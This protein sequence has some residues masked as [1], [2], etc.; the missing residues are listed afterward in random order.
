MTKTAAQKLRQKEKRKAKKQQQ[1]SGRSRSRSAASSRRSRSASSKCSVRTDSAATRKSFPSRPTRKASVR[2]A[3]VGRSLNLGLMAKRAFAQATLPYDAKMV[4]VRPHGAGC[5]LQSTAM[6]RNFAVIDIDLSG[7]LAVP[8]DAN[9]PSVHLSSSYNQLVPLWGDGRSVQVVQLHDPLIYGIYPVANPASVHSIYN[10]TNFVSEMCVDTQLHGTSG[11]SAALNCELGCWNGAIGQNLAPS[12]FLPAAGSP[13][14]K[15]GNLLPCFSRNKGG[16]S[17]LRY[18]W[19]DASPAKP[20]ALTVDLATVAPGHFAAGDAYVR[21][22][23]LNYS[24]TVDVISAPVPVT[25]PGAIGTVA[26]NIASSGCYAVIILGAMSGAA[27]AG[28]V[29]TYRPKLTLDMQTTLATNYVFN[30]NLWDTRHQVERIQVNGSAVLV[31]NTQAVMGRGNMVYAVSVGEQDAWWADFT[32]DPAKKIIATNSSSRYGGKWEEGIYGF[33]RPV[34]AFKFEEYFKV[35]PSGLSENFT[36]LLDCDGM[37]VFSIGATASADFSPRA[38]AHFC[39]V[40]EFTT[41][42]QMFVKDVSEIGQVETGELVDLLQ[43]QQPFTENPLHWSSILDA[44]R[45]GANKVLE[46]APTVARYANA[47]LSIASVLAA[48]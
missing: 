47:G 27:A 25:A 35:N 30:Q 36:D 16:V 7:V 29:M 45:S 31:Q 2:M 23:R 22:M 44:I 1:G 24:E 3:G 4:R 33:N 32:A 48:L 8:V 21:L 18:F 34:R 41:Q 15:Y 5:S 6:A 19:V 17:S 39:V 37:S 13:G 28:D 26:F 42:S 11:A 43:R 40:Y 10:A 38:T 46:W 9:V 14:A 12:H 20:A